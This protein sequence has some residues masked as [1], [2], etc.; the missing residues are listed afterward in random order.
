MVVSQ[1]AEHMRR[2]LRRPNL[3]LHKKTSLSMRGRTRTLSG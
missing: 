1:V 2:T 3:V